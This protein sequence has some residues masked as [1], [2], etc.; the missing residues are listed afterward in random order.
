MRLADIG[1]EGWFLL[2]VAPVIGSFLGVLVLRLPEG[3]AIVWSRSRCE[4]CGTVLAPRDLVP[5][6]SWLATRG[7]CR[8]CGH[9]LGWFYPGIEMAA[10]LIAVI[11]LGVDGTPRAWLDCLFG[12]WLLALGWIDLRRWV[13]PDTLTLP[14]IVAGLLAA[15]LFDPGALFDRALGAALGYL[16]LRGVAAAYRAVRGQEGLGRGDAKLLG[17]GGSWVG[18]SAMPQVILAAALLALVTV[19]AL[20]LVGV[21]LHAHSAVP[22]GP[23]LALSIWALWLFGP[24]LL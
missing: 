13:L 1:L 5:L 10:L 3:E 21:R 6:V 23:F 16:V 8:R 11:A 9:R 2:A 18:V 4:A 14:L 20:R 22:F 12:W 24:V 19:G 15:K 7:R 17:A